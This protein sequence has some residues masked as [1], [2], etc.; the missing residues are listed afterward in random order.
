MKYYFEQAALNA[1]TLLLQSDRLSDLSVRIFDIL[2]LILC[3][4]IRGEEIARNKLQEEI[5]EEKKKKKQQG[6]KLILT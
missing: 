1:L 2:I 5:E 6:E 3:H 4:V